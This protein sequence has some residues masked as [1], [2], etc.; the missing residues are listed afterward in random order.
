MLNY[1]RDTWRAATLGERAILVSCLTYLVW[2]FDLFPEALFGVLGLT[3][4]FA[5]VAIL[6]TKVKQIRARLQPE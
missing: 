3:D 5:A 6:V 1:I 2:P 4:D